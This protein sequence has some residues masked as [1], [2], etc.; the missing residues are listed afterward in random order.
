M[1]TC[2][3]S[4]SIGTIVGTAVGTATARGNGTVGR[5][6]GD[7]DDVNLALAAFGVFSGPGDS[8]GFATFFFFD[9]APFFAASFFFAAFAF[10]A[11]LGD[12]LAFEGAEAS[13]NF[14]GVGVASSSAAVFF[15]SSLDDREALGRGVSLGFAFAFFGV[16]EGVALFFA[17]FAFGEGVGD[18]SVSGVLT[19]GSRFGLPSLSC[20]QR[21]APISALI[22][23]VIAMQMRKRG[24]AERNRDQTAFNS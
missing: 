14:F 3:G 22:A 4:S 20:A 15:F 1:L 23:K 17:F 16:G 2:A 12:F 19:N 11:G 7:G 13:G 5:S 9:A 6:I 24:T 21:Y 18:A 10:A 8:S